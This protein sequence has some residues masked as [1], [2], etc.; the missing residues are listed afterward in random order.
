MA[1]IDFGKLS[2]T[3]VNEVV[4][5]LK[6]DMQ[7]YAKEVEIDTRQFIQ[8]MSQDLQRWTDQLEKGEITQ[9]NLERFVKAKLDLMKMEALKNA[10][11]GLIELDKVKN[12]I[13]LTV[14]DFVL[15]VLIKL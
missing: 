8:S 15:G 4:L 7:G 13:L 9:R 14:I 10:G 1:A 5:L 2:Q 3:V 12:K 11:I 6:T